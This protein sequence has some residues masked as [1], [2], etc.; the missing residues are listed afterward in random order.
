MLN[1]RDKQLK[2]NVAD[3]QSGLYYMTIETKGNRSVTKR[4]VVE[5]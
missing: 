2:F 1:D 5:N 3:Y 4:F